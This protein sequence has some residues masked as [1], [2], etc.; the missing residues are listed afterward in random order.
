MEPADGDGVGVG[1][2]VPHFAYIFPSFVMSMDGVG[3]GVTLF[4]PPDG[5]GTGSPGVRVGVVVDVGVGVGVTNGHP[6]GIGV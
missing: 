4:I 3:V 1:S 2:I 5:V 6:D